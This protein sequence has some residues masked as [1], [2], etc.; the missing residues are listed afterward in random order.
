MGIL[1][2]GRNMERSIAAL[3]VATALWFSA[4]AAALL[5]LASV[6]AAQT[7]PHDLVGPS[8]VYLKVDYTPT[9]GPFSGVRR[10]VESTGFIVSDDGFI[11]TSYDPLE[12]SSKFAGD[13][14]KITAS[15]GDPEAQAVTA[16]IFDSIQQLDVMLL[17]IRTSKPLPHLTLGKAEVLN[18]ND[19]IYT[20]GFLGKDPFNSEGTLSNKFGP[21]GVG[22]LWTLNMPVAPGESGS[23]VYL[24]DGAVVGILKGQSTGASNVGYMVPIEFS[25]A[26]IAHL[27][28]SELDR[29]VSELN[30][31]IATLR[32][33]D[34]QVA[35]LNKQVSDLMAKVANISEY[36]QQLNRVIEWSG[37]VEDGQ[38]VLMYHKLVAGSTQVR[39]V[40]LSLIV[41]ETDVKTRETRR[42]LPLVRDTTARDVAVTSERGGRVLVP[43][44]GQL[45]DFRMR[46]TPNIVISRVE[47]A[48]VANLVDDTKLDPV[49]LLIDI[50]SGKLK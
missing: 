45:A 42:G 8:L 7:S 31:R 30:T 50:D 3:R 35:D 2:L 23:P 10:T 5:A 15:V 28:L 41:W 12:E 47:V 19:R 44:F 1:T 6:A 25:D 32:Q 46:L 16:G 43:E 37:E 40:Y 24:A 38:L 4:C 36:T 27:R 21:L 18:N 33:L 22:Y 48:I 49:T 34:S 11:L 13:D 9:K 29:R 26:L 14:V 39:N 17:K 20:S